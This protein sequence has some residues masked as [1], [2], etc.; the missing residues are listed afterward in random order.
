MLLS[1]SFQAIHILPPLLPALLGRPFVAD[2]PPDPL[3]SSLFELVKQKVG[4]RGNV[5][6]NCK[7]DENRFTCRPRRRAYKRPVRVPVPW[8][9]A[10]YRVTLCL[11]WPKASSR[12]HQGRALEGSAGGPA[13][14]KNQMDRIRVTHKNSVY[15]ALLCS[16]RGSRRQTHTLQVAFMSTPGLLFTAGN[17]IALAKVQKLLSLLFC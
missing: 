1:P 14:P 12:P 15:L 3:Q 16:D 7:D 10:V 9:E 11:L 8:T 13:A 5:I 6:E 4:Q 17:L 2:L